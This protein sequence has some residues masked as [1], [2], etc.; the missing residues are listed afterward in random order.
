[1][2]DPPRYWHLLG[3]V[4]AFL[5]VGV[6]ALLLRW[7]YSG[8]P[9]SLL[10]SKTRSGEPDEYGL[11]VSVAKPASPAEGITIRDRLESAGL[12]VTLAETRSGLHVLVW[13]ADETKARATLKE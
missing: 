6:I 10:S 7:A 2:E 1:V 9:S 12:R 13:P 8:R 4:T 3:P 5:V 11:L